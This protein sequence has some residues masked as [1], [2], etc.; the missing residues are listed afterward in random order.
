MKNIFAAVI[1]SVFTLLGTVTEAGESVVDRSALETLSPAA[2]K[3]LKNLERIQGA[4][5]A[6][7]DLPR[8]M[9]S[10]E[11]DQ[12]YQIEFFLF[13]TDASNAYNEGCQERFGRNVVVSVLVRTEHLTDLSDD[14]LGLLLE[15]LAKV[16]IGTRSQAN[17]EAFLEVEREAFR[18]AAAKASVD[19]Q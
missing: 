15:G 4:E 17:Q 18:R 6:E 13:C 12:Q 2:Y 16:A 7:A 3:A 10:P 9:K 19:L 14:D 5:V 1:A 11:F 8:T